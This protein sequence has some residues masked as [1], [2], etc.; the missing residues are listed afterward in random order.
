MSPQLYNVIQDIFILPRVCVLVP[1]KSWRI[2]SRGEYK[3]DQ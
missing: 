3:Q 2:T 1:Q